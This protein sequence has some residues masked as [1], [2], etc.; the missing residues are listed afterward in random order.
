MTTEAR[1][2]TAEAPQ[3]D[4]ALEAE[5]E[6][7]A[8]EVS[9]PP[10]EEPR[11]PG[12]LA[13]YLKFEVKD[14]VKHKAIPMLVIAVLG[15]WI[16]HHYYG[17]ALAGQIG[18]RGRPIDAEGEPLLFRMIVTVG[19][20]LFGGLGTLISVNGIVSRDREG[21]YQRFLFA[22]PVRITRF[23][24]QRFAVGG[25]GLLATA[26]IMLMMT[27][28]AFLRPV[29]F[30][31]PMIAIA[32]T[33]VAV[34]GLAF[35]ISTLVRFDMAATLALTLLSLP[36]YA[37]SQQGKWWG[38]LASWVLPPMHYL[39]ALDPSPHPH[40]GTPSLLL[41]VSM[42]W[43]YGAAYVAAGVAVLKKRSIMR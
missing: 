7:M 33:Y 11:E 21:G 37:A 25:L 8:L 14:F 19:S 40:A 12:G 9:A 34:G 22:K 42:M 4:D 3:L 2:R 10:L 23:Y 27:S 38:M 5:L 32:A 17:M 41:A 35:L 6:R 30:I 15:I 31:E 13:R 29:P 43:T 24:L 39:E 28:L 16:F 20:L 1:T 36:M 26:A 18:P